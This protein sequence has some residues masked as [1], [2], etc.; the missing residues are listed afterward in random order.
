MTRE[1]ALKVLGNKASH[2]RLLVA[3]LVEG[4]PGDNKRRG[5]Q[6]ELEAV[7]LALLDVERARVVELMLDGQAPAE[8]SA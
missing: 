4:G 6:C 3:Q 8:A 1:K 2:L 7:E 5:L